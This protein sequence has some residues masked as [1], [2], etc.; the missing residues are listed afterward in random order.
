MDELTRGT[1]EG[2]VV[3]AYYWLK[4]RLLLGLMVVAFFVPFF[5]I[6]AAITGWPRN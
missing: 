5:A 3:K 1:T 6:W 2:P 4:G